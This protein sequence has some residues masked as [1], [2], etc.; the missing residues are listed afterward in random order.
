MLE[1]ILDGCLK[2]SLSCQRLY[3][4]TAAQQ[5]PADP[6]LREG[7]PL[8]EGLHA[9]IP[10]QDTCIRLQSMHCCVQHL[11]PVFITCGATFQSGHLILQTSTCCATEQGKY[12]RSGQ[13]QC[14]IVVKS[15]MK[16]AIDSSDP[17]NQRR[18]LTNGLIAQYVEGTEAVA[19]ALQ[20]R[21][22]S[23]AE[24][25]PWCIRRPCAAVQAHIH[26]VLASS[27]VK[28]PASATTQNAPRALQYIA[29]IERK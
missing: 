1:H 4:V 17:L 27:S 29:H 25:A 13:T 22:H 11:W 26:P 15:S 6:E 12:T 2:G 10:Q 3:D 9:L 7:G 20:S 21:H 14:H 24:A 23:P 18:H 28:G 5:L 8:A 19:C 16:Y